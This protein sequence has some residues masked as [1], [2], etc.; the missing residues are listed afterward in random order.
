MPVRLGARRSR[1]GAAGTAAYPCRHDRERLP[2]L[3]VHTERYLL[4]RDTAFLVV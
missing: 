2:F 1:K 4:D 3:R